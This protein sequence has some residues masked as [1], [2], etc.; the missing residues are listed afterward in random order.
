MLPQDKVQPQDIG[1]H[2]R[3][4]LEKRYFEF[5]KRIFAKFQI[6]FQNKWIQNFILDGRYDEELYQATV[7]EWSEALFGIEPD[8]MRGA[9]KLIRDTMIWPPSPAEF[10]SVCEKLGGLPDEEDVYDE[11]IFEKPIHSISSRIYTKLGTYII[12]NSLEKDLR[13][14]VKVLYEKYV[15]EEKVNL[16]R[17]VCEEFPLISRKPDQLEKIENN[18]ILTNLKKNNGFVE[19]LILSKDLK[20]FPV[21]NKDMIQPGNRKFNEEAYFQRKKYLLELPTEQW[22]NLKSEDLYDRLRF[23]GEEQIKKDRKILDPIVKPEVKKR[24]QESIKN[25]H[26]DWINNS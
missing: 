2:A 15:L 5:T 23:E 13:L 8:I 3:K 19:G 26:D 22:V 7:S 21:W 24:Y 1:E 20:G 6:I 9:V 16:Y 4:D 10:L 11:I 17:Q 25:N 18:P 14:R 12:K